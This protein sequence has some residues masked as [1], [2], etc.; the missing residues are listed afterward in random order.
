MVTRIY[1]GRRGH[2]FIEEWMRQ[3]NI[4]DERLANRLGVARETVTRWRRQQ[5]RLNPG[6]IAAIASALDLEPVDL[7]RAPSDR[8]SLDALVRNASHELQT[9]VADIVRRLVRR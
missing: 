1:K 6:K 2:L 9:T 4:S 5:H 3:R 7:W 8:P